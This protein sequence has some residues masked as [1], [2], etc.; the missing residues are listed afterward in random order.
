VSTA[1][2]AE[3]VLLGCTLIWGL[4]FVTVKASLASADTQTFLALRFLLGGVVLAL[5]AGR[6]LLNAAA[7]RI[8][9]PMGVLLFVSYWLH[10]TTA[11]RSAFITGL[12]VVLV[13]WVSWALRAGRPSVVSIVA[14][15]VAV[16]G[17][18]LM[19]DPQAGAVVVGDW[20]TLGCTVTYAAH[21]V[22]TGRVA[23]AVPAQPMVA[24]QLLVV[25]ALSGV[26]AFFGPRHLHSTPSLWFG[27]V[28]T[29]LLASA[30]AISLQTWAQRFASPVRA[31]L[32]FSLEPVVAALASLWWGEI[33]TWR[34]VAGGG[35]IVAA[36]VCAE[37]MA[38]K[39]LLQE[40]NSYAK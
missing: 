11:A 7:W 5:L 1:R 16:A 2:L 21:I 25:A 32:L 36:V 38:S 24:V 10:T 20:L 31:A 14:T 19:T 13:P 8:G 4:T 29:G 12:T 33:L 27:I 26:A 30:L 39:P 28:T 3:W 17:L 23:Q 37:L 15:G 22:L 9:T 18:W 34:T 40:E 35:L 6:R